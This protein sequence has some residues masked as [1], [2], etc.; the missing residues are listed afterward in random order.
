MNPPISLLFTAS[1]HGVTVPFPIIT[2]KCL[3]VRTQRRVHEYIRSVT[4]MKSVGIHCRFSA[5]LI[6]HSLTHIT[7]TY[8]TLD[9]HP[10]HRVANAAHAH[11]CLEILAQSWQRSRK[12]THFPLCDERRD[13][14]RGRECSCILTLLYYCFWQLLCP[15]PCQT[16]RKDNFDKQGKMPSLLQY[17]CALLCDGEKKVA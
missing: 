2:D 8:F 10:L 3:C 1:F 14:T 12:D 6:I 17:S 7:V 15:F 13:T 5:C 9:G 11:K 16:Q 4:S